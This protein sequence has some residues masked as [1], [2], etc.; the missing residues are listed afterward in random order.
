[1]CCGG[2]PP[3]RLRR[4]IGDSDCGEA[5]PP[6]S[7]RPPPAEP[8]DSRLRA[9]APRPFLPITP[10][11]R[12]RCS[13][14]CCSRS[15]TRASAAATSLARRTAVGSSNATLGTAPPPAPAMDEIRCSSPGAGAEPDRPRRRVPFADS[16]SA[17]RL[18]PEASA[19]RRGENETKGSP[20]ALPLRLRVPPLPPPLLRLEEAAAPAEERLVRR[21]FAAASEAAV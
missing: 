1:M 5:P 9:D 15:A 11:S 6:P 2:D 18:P 19:L 21:L 13:N 12:R 16:S 4:R 7:E 17:S 14:A 10:P 20:P 3:L 8:N